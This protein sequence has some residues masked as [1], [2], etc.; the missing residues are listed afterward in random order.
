MLRNRAAVA[1][2]AITCLAMMANGFLFVIFGTWMESRYRLLVT[3][4]G[5]ATAVIGIAELL[6]ESGV[7]GLVDRL[8]KR[9]SAAIGLGF[10]A[11]GYVALT[12]NSV[13]LWAALIWLRFSSVS[14]LWLWRPFRW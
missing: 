11:A 4:L 13:D 9:R 2:L 8:G 1:A 6:G 5:V 14:S 7:G 3:R 10:T 12:L